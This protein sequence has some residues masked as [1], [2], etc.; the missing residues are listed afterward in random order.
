MKVLIAASEAIPYVKTGGLADVTGSLLKEYRKTGIDAFLMLPLYRRVR[1][2]FD[3]RD[4]GL[5]AKVPVGGR[6]FSFRIL[7]FEEVSFFLECDEFFDREELY[8]TPAGDYPDNAERFTFFSRAVLE[9]CIVLGL[10]PDVIHCND[11]QTGLLPVYLKSLY[12]TEFFRGTATVMTI[13]NLGYQGIFDA[14]CFT[15][16]GLP[17]GWFNPEGMEFYGKVNFLKAGIVA[18]DVLTTVSSTY[19]KEILTPEFGYG[20]DG[21]LR[22]RSADL[23]GVINGIDY[24][25]FDPAHGLGIPARY[26]ASDLSGKSQCREEL[27]RECGLS[28]GE[29]APVA[30]MIGRLSAQKGI[31]IFLSAAPEIVSS[32][33]KL[34]VLGKGDEEYQKGVISLGK[35]HRD[36]VS[37]RIGY[38]EAFARRIYAGSDMILMPSLYEPCGLSQII[39]MRYGAVPVARRTGGLADTITDHDSLK[40]GGTGFLFRD[41]SAAVFVECLKRAL[42]VY[43]DKRRW[44]RIMTAA[45]KEDFSWK[46]SAREYIELYEK[47]IKSRKQ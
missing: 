11:W 40:G 18:S 15:L 12:R 28:A 46:N 25:E 37:V 7:S 3:L 35:E 19:A 8:G 44:R 29:K 45:M 41:Y 20:L 5:T 42:C 9:A 4:T 23:Y 13:H 17:P 14:S 22:R 33:V 10:R 21:V 32:G 36:S 24:G 27:L 47:A 6:S 31:D 1:E 16:S 34:V 30:S 39:A 38:D 43:A 2:E 26:D